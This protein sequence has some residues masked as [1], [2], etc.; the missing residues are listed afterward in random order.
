MRTLHHFRTSLPC[1]ENISKRSVTSSSTCSRTSYLTI[2]GECF[3]QIF[4]TA[5]PIQT[6]LHF[7]ARSSPCGFRNDQ[8]RDM[9][10]RGY[11]RPAFLSRSPRAETHEELA[12]K[13]LFPAIQFDLFFYQRS[14]QTDPNYFLPCFFMGTP[15]AICP[16]KRCLGILFENSPDGM[17]ERL[18]P[19]RRTPAW[20]QLLQKTTPVRF[21][22]K[23][24]GEGGLRY[25]NHLNRVWGTCYSPT[26]AI[27]LFE[28]LYRG[29]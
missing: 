27:V 15:V 5:M 16:S 11:V 25:F 10:R 21:C 22:R 12:S 24:R 19:I 18:A 3:C 17:R 8:P 6:A 7:R 9:I 13:S 4:R 26:A 1:R 29:R 23:I 2:L 20:E 14:D 28:F